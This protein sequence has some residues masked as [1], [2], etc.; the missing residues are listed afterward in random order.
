M[1]QTHTELIQLLPLF[2]NHFAQL[3]D[4]F[5]SFCNNGVQ[6]EAWFKGEMLT[7]LDRLKNEG[8]LTGFDREVKTEYGRIDL[9]I[10]LGAVRH[11]I[12]LKHWLIGEQKGIKYKSTFY[13]GD[14]S[15][16]GIIGDVK[17]LQSIT[18]PGEHWL[19]I[20]TTANPGQ[21]AWNSG[22]DKF[23]DKFAP[24]KLVPET[25]PDDYPKPY[26]LGLLRVM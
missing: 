9:A 3:Q 11:W 6:T 2:K 12:E 10:D 8:Q 4:R 22:I 16:A 24:E 5:I 19:L 20:L 25:N 17:K 26:F 1:K 14:R 13:F 15:S 21:E 23:N 18:E 7:L